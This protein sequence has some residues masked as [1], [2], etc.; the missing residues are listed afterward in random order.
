MQ[1]FLRNFLFLISNCLLLVSCTPEMFKGLKQGEE[2]FTR[3]KTKLFPLGIKE[4]LVYKTNIKYKDK[5]FSS[6]A[7]V[8]EINDSVFKIVLLTSFG[9]TLLVAE[10]SKEKFIVNNVISYLD[11]K[12]ILNLLENDWRI[13]LAGNLSA[14]IPLQFSSTKPE[15]QVFDYQRGR[16]NNLYYYNLKQKVLTQIESYKGKTKKVVVSISSYK[17]SM[18]E[19]FSIEHPS[20]KLK[21]DMTLL[22]KVNNE[23]AE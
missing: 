5:E 6:L 19:S 7:Y 3:D 10:I 20:L 14:D 21:L 23:S 11:R 4:S 12:P 18:P 15:E 17:D 16:I 1:K 13:V 9:N 8:N 22:K 2:T